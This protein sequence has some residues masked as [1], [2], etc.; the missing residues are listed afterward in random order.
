MYKIIANDLQRCELNKK[1]ILQMAVKAIN[2]IIGSNGL[3]PI[4]LIFKAYFCISKFDSFIST[5]I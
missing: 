4:F 1:I 3:V 2:N 5:I